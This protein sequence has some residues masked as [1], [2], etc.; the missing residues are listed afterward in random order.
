LR[1]PSWLQV[2]KVTVAAPVCDAQGNCEWCETP[3]AAKVYS[4]NDSE[5]YVERNLRDED[6]DNEICASLLAHA[7]MPGTLGAT[8]PALHAATRAPVVRVEGVIDAEGSFCGE[9]ASEA[10]M[11]TR[12]VK[13][14]VLELFDGSLHHLVR[15]AA[16]DAANAASEVDVLR[17][18][19][20]IACGL[21]LLHNRGVIVC[22]LKSENI[23]ILVRSKCRTSSPAL[24][25]VACTACS[26]WDSC[27][28]SPAT[29]CLCGW[30]IWL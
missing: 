15:A 27:G 20:G 24:S 13:G 6:A 30:G 10:L 8:N 2:W 5:R 16:G 1:P 12:E 26:H 17:V 11:G 25:H 7:A 3:A 18:A 14:L 4:R 9:G 22:D 23:L 29:M 19:Q 28:V 21:G